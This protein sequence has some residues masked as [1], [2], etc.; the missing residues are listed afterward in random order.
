[1]GDRKASYHYSDLQ[2]YVRKYKRSAPEG[3]TRSGRKKQGID[4]LSEMAKLLNRFKRGVNSAPS[5]SPSKPIGCHQSPKTVSGSESLSEA[6][7]SPGR[8][9]RPTFFF[10]NLGKAAW[11]LDRIKPVTQAARVVVAGSPT[12]RLVKGILNPRIPGRL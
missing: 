12:Q 6:G 8:D 9:D 10:G 3:E 7:D 2:T 11:R 4:D 1:M 5:S